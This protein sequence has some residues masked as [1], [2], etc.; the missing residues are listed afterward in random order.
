MSK[1]TAISALNRYSREWKGLSISEL[2]EYELISVAVAQ[3]QNKV[4]E[5]QLQKALKTVPPKPNQVL[6]AEGGRIMW[7]GQN[8]YMVILEQQNIQADRELASKLADCAYCSLQTDAW[9]GLRV[10]GEHVMDVFERFI[11]L[12][13][14]NTAMDFAARTS[15]HH[16]AVMVVKNQDGS[17]LLLT[18]RSSARSFLNALI[19][20]IDN[21]LI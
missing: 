2:T 1:L 14:S 8:Q 7:T 18:P 6:P 15:A 9:T 16:H 20:T 5:D 4:F 21:V 3:G 17:I 12:D 10:V 13:L 11:P 19:H